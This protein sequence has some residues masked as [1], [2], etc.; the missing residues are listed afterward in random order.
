MT[1]VEAGRKPRRRLGATRSARCC[2][3]LADDPHQSRPDGHDGDRRDDDGPARPGG[4]CRRRARLEPLLPP[5]D[6]RAR[7]DDRRLADDR[8]RTRPQAA[9]RSATC[10]ARCG[11]GLWIAVMVAIPI[12]I[13]LW[14]T[15]AILVGIGQ[16]PALAAHAGSMCAPCNGRCCLSTATSCC[17]RS[18]RRWSVR[19][20]RWS[21]CSSRSPSTRSPPGA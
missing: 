17:A 19:A 2:S 13:V 16:D 8:D 21:S 10:A 14:N 3:S 11:Q 18:S 5:A 1:A 7:P 12:W 15:E 4:A 20:G 6:L 9:I